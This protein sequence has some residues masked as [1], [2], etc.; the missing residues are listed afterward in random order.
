MKAMEATDPGYD[1]RTILEEI[2]SKGIKDTTV[3]VNMAQLLA[4]KQDDHKAMAILKQVTTCPEL[5]KSKLSVIFKIISIIGL[6]NTTLSNEAFALLEAATPHIRSDCTT[7]Q[8]SVPSVANDNNILA[9][10][11]YKINFLLQSGDTEKA[12]KLI[13]EMERAIPGTK[14]LLLEKAYEDSSAWIWGETM[15]HDL[16][17]KIRAAVAGIDDINY[18]LSDNFGN[19][20]IN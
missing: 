11:L 16:A 9:S 1:W 10:W 17:V 18:E 12:Y 3:L 6:R 2:E 20:H 13:V 19:F 5:C 8:T 15:L 14:E 7:E 4:I